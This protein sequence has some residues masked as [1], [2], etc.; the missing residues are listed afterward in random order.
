VLLPVLPARAY[1]IPVSASTTGNKAVFVAFIGG[2][3][4]DTSPQ[5]N[6]AT[7]FYRAFANCGAPLGPLVERPDCPLGT[8]YTGPDVKELQ[9]SSDFAA[10]C[11][12]SG[13]RGTYALSAAGCVLVVL[14]ALGLFAVLFACST[15]VCA[16]TLAWCSRHGGRVMP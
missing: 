7:T 9:A 16:R 4:V 11:C 3:T 8:F 13:V 12:V 1:T 10:Q 14:E 6:T 5:D 15:C 2:N